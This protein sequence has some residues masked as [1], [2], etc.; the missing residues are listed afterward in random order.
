MPGPKGKRSKEVREQKREQK[1]DVKTRTYLYVE[2]K[3]QSAGMGFF[4][5]SFLIFGISL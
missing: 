5:I 3:F 1:K 4:T 2:P